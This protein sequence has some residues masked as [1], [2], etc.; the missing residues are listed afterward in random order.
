MPLTVRRGQTF[1]AAV[2]AALQNPPTELRPTTSLTDV[3]GPKHCWPGAANGDQGRRRLPLRRAPGVG[4]VWTSLSRGKARTAG[5]SVPASEALGDGAAA[6]TR[7]PGMLWGPARRVCFCNRAHFRA[8]C[9]RLPVVF[10]R[11]RLVAFALASASARAKGDLARASFSP[12]G[13]SRAGRG[14]CPP[15][16]KARHRGHPRRQSVGVGDA[17]NEQHLLLPDL[18][19]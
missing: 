8:S 18:Q 13:P 5:A 6:P 1:R 10:T 11:S 9:S 2:C 16:H 4:R 14:F 19:G 17:L 12:R 3:G 7:L 15:G